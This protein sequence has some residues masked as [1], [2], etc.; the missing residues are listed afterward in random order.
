MPSA[1]SDLHKATRLICDVPK[2]KANRQGSQPGL[3]FHFSKLP[4]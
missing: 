2:I 1:V 4:K 3:Q